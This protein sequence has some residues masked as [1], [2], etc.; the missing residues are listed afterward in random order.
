MKISRLVR[1]VLVIVLLA[2]SGG[3][4]VYSARGV[5]HTLGQES[6]TE[7]TVTN[8]SL[9]HQV[10]RTPDG[11]L[12]NPYAQ[13]AVEEESEEASSSVESADVTDSD[14]QALDVAAK[15]KPAKKKPAKKPAPKKPAKKKPA[16]KKP[17][18]ACPT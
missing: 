18:P 3:A 10:Q 13:A 14:E 12:V 8:L 17:A 6:V 15:K 11:T 7:V 1:Y 5:R 16:P 4:I 2:L 9:N